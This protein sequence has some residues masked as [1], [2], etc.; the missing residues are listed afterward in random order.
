[1]RSRSFF[2][3]ALVV[4]VACG[5]AETRE[6]FEGQAVSTPTDPAD[7]NEDPAP[8]GG[9]FGNDATAGLTLEPRNTT[10]VIDLATSPA[11]PGSVVYALTSDGKDVAGAKFSLSD[12]TLGSFSGGTFTSVD[13]LPEGV[14]GKSAT[15]TAKTAKGGKALAT[16]TVVALRKSGPQRD[17][18][19]IVPHGDDPSPKSDVLTFSTNIKQADVAFVMDTTGSM[20]GSITNLKNALKSTLLTQLQAAI[21]NVGLAIVDYKDYPTSP[22]GQPP[23]LVFA[24]DHPVRVHQKITTSLTAAISAVDKYSASGGG[25]LPESQIPAM[26]HVLT[27]E[28]LLTG[29][30]NVA[31]VPS[32][33]TAWGGVGFRSGSVPV[34]VNITDVNWH[35]EGN[36]PYNFATPTMASLKAAFQAKQ[37]VFVNVTCAPGATNCGSSDE[38]QANELSDATGSYV[39]ASAFGGA[40][41][42]GMCCTG[43]SGAARA[44]TGPGGTCRLNFQHS[45]GAGVST[46][47]VKAIEAIAVGTNFD[48]KA[49]PSNDPANP[50]GVDATQFIKALR[51]MDEGNAAAGCPPTA[52]TDSDGDGVLDTF[53]GVRAG[54]PVCFEVIANKNTVVPAEN[55]PQFFNAFIDVVG[56]PGN[57]PLDRRSVLFLVPPRDAGVK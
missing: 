54:T 36:A 42:A 7:P 34:V 47:V 23:F 6:S 16:L 41:G 20:D 18:F 32:T 48:V 39:P 49:V 57:L 40:C 44:P 9:G 12:P 19:F 26:Q 21:P 25:D 37:A 11:T 55:A 5:G 43:V 53:V 28:S 8:S 22:Y 38:S 35:G 52:A 13:A 15:V 45:N 31:S 2:L 10:V 24:G 14:L 56:V 3:G 17:F 51:A 4:L 1:M 29:G 46:G 33:A 30:A 50:G 27:G